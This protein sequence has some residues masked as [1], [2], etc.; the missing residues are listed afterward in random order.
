MEPVDI[1]P[2]DEIARW[3]GQLFV[4]FFFFITL[5]MELS[6]TK[7][8]EP[9]IRALLSTA[10]QYCEAVVLEPRNIPRDCLD[11]IR[12][13]AWPAYRTVSGVRLC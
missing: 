2:P 11:V 1:Q 13:E 3:S 6:D 10:S 5:G 7:V 9:Y 4:F 12:K 8:Y